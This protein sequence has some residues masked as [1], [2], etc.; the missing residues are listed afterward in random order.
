MR[1]MLEKLDISTL[2]VLLED[3]A[4][5]IPEPEQSERFNFWHLVLREIRNEI[6]RRLKEDYE[7]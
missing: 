3:L 5:I 6:D 7:K 2:W 1:K 4:K